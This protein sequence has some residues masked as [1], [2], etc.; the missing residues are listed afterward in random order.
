MKTIKT[1]LTISALFVSIVSCDNN[2]TINPD[3]N[4]NFT[5]LFDDVEQKADSDNSAKVLWCCTN[6][7]CGVEAKTVKTNLETYG[8]VI[9]PNCGAV[10]SYDP[11]T[12]S[13]RPMYQTANPSSVVYGF[14]GGYAKDYTGASFSRMDFV[15]KYGWDPV[16]AWN[17]IQSGRPRVVSG[18]KCN[19]REVKP[20]S[21]TP[22]NNTDSQSNNNTA[23]SEENGQ[24]N[25]ATEETKTCQNLMPSQKTC[26]Y[27][28]D[29]ECVEYTSKSGAIWWYCNDDRPICNM[30]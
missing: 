4:N 9:C 2:E 13:L 27:S 23:V 8:I 3:E 26:S 12:N 20:I 25:P 19:Y 11:I 28:C 14:V 21:V 22:P 6:P 17:W 24:T 5:D 18:K 15:N 16:R 29:T 7:E 30:L 10:Y 1:F